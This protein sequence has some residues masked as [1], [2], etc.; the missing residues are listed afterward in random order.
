MII[1]WGRKGLVAGALAVTF[2]TPV[3]IP[4][5]TYIHEVQH[6][7][8][9]KFEFRHVTPVEVV[10]PPSTGGGGGYRFTPYKNPFEQI[11]EDNEGIEIIQ[12][13]LMTGV[14]DD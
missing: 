2:I 4:P 14:L 10:T 9:F 13:I 1:K 12:M 3:V 11:E 7:P 6:R 8:S 5:A